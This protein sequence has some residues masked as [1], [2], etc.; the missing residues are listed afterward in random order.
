VE[1]KGENEGKSIKKGKIQIYQGELQDPASP[2]TQPSRPAYN[3]KREK[4]RNQAPTGTIKAKGWEEK[5]EEGKGERN[6][7][8]SNV[9]GGETIWQQQ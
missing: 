9:G 1:E 2:S 7:G 3:K 4:K 8:S 5:G 6:T